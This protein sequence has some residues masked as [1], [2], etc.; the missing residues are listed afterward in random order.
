MRLARKGRR[1]FDDVVAV[2]RTH[3]S[4]RRRIAPARY[5]KGKAI[6]LED[7]SPFHGLFDLLNLCKRA[8][9]PSPH[10]HPLAVTSV[11][12]SKRIIP[13]LSHDD[14]GSFLLRLQS[15]ARS[16]S[17]LFNESSTT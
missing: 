16:A 17:S 5:T 14:A 10:S 2:R 13:V 3:G 6:A 4:R 11:H 1:S 15:I 9:G 8:D 12:H 7:F